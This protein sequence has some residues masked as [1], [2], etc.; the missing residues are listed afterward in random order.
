MTANVTKS[1]AKP[2]EVYTV[3]EHR[4][5]PSGAADGIVGEIRGLSLLSV[6]QH[7]VNARKFDR[8]IVIHSCDGK[9]LNKNHLLHR[10]GCL[11]LKE[12]GW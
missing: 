11:L 8:R 2:E 10:A 5:T 9:I 1:N 6:A 3:V 4:H 12:A 7:I